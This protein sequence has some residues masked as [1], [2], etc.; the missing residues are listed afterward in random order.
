MRAAGLPVVRSLC[1][2]DKHTHREQVKLWLA[3]MDR[4]DHSFSQKLFGAM[5]RA[6][7]SDW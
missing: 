3:Q 4:E 1:P 6:H 7:L 5:Q 2:A